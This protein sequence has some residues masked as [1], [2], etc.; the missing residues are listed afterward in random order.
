MGGFF[1]NE[2]SKIKKPAQETSGLLIRGTRQKI[3]I[4]AVGT[5]Y[6]VTS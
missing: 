5:A 6:P 4:L 2:I 1:V 3:K